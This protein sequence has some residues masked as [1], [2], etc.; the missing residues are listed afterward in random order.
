MLE[1]LQKAEALLG[2]TRWCRCPILLCRESSPRAVRHGQARHR[3]PRKERSRGQECRRL[4]APA[5]TTEKMEI[6]RR[7]SVLCESTWQITCRF[8]KSWDLCRT[9]VYG[10]EAKRQSDVRRVRVCEVLQRKRTQRLRQPKCRE[11]VVQRLHS[12]AYFLLWES[13][14]KMPLS[15]Y[16]D[17]GC[18]DSCRRAR[19]ERF[20]R[21]ADFWRAECSRSLSR[22]ESLSRGA[23]GSA[24]TLK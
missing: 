7:R 5:L 11:P 10:G 14:R 18:S 16:D 15:R 17:S 2:W 1:L 19:R 23:I 6:P 24:E 22:A 8:P 4:W 20:L 3:N 13:S 9:N 21:G 12:L